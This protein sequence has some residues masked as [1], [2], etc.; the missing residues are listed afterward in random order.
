MPCRTPK[1][2]KKSLI[3]RFI[4]IGF[5]FAKLTVG[6]SVKLRIKKCWPY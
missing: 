3:L 6:G 1:K 2:K 5:H 4:F